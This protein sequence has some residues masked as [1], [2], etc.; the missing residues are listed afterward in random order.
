[1][2]RYTRKN[3]HWARVAERNGWSI[4]VQNKTTD[5]THS[6]AADE[7]EDVAENKSESE[8]KST[9]PTEY[10]YFVCG[11]RLENEKDF[12][13]IPDM[14]ED[15]RGC[16][17]VVY[18][19]PVVDVSKVEEDHY[20]QMRMYARIFEDFEYPWGFLDEDMAPSIPS[21]HQLAE[22][23]ELDVYADYRMWGDN[24][25]TSCYFHIYRE[26]ERERSCQFSY[27]QTEGRFK[28]AASYNLLKE[29]FQCHKDR[30]ER[31]YLM[32]NEGA[33]NDFCTWWPLLEHF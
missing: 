7:G 20:T 2:G 32:W 14:D 4:E 27:N 6:E 11:Y 29:I 26:G 28:S 13:R 1:M 9:K 8:P 5:D 21:I 17:V 12:M 10:A 19:V 30:G 16:R 22:D 33:D 15:A 24:H 23:E 3:K 25:P 18:A 31:G